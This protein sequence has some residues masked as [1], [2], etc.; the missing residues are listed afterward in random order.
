[1]GIE[2]SVT[3]MRENKALP[4]DTR[5]PDKITLTITNTKSIGTCLNIPSSKRD[6]YSFR[7]AWLSFGTLAFKLKTFIDT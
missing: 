5:K 7:K 2:N 3:W 1:M 6:L 4:T